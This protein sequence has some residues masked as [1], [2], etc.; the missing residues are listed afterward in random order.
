MFAWMRR[1]WPF[2]LK[3]TYI[4]ESNAHESLR[5]KREL[6]LSRLVDSERNLHAARLMREAMTERFKIEQKR[7]ETEKKRADVAEEM[8]KSMQEKMTYMQDR[9]ERMLR[10]DP[11]WRHL[12]K[13]TIAI[14]RNN[15]YKVAY[16]TAPE[17]FQTF[18]DDS[19]VKSIC[20]THWVDMETFGVRINIGLQKECPPELFISAIRDQLQKQIEMAVLKRW[21]DQSVLLAGRNDDRPRSI[22]Q[23]DS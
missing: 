23:D 3:Q 5:A 4:D 17:F 21:Q 7:A 2:V 18:G 10:D 20:Q 22:H 14:V 11:E 13:K 12:A 8:Q 6:V 15:Q 9:V 1:L 16:M 19:P